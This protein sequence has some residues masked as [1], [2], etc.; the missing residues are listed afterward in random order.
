MKCSFVLESPDE[1]NGKAQ[2]NTSGNT[3]K[4][5]T[6]TSVE[7]ETAGPSKKIALKNFAMRAVKKYKDPSPSTVGKQNIQ[8]ASDISHLCMLAHF[9]LLL[10]KVIEDIN[11][12]SNN[13]FNIRI[14]K[15]QNT[16][17]KC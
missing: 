9:A 16:D 10:K 8:K 2:F 1:N 7:D 15:I 3:I 5:T 4:E 6:F 13:Q 17:I 14:G 12:H 11:K